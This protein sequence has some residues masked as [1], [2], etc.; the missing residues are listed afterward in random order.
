MTAV[1]EPLYGA[2]AAEIGAQLRATTLDVERL[3]VEAGAIVLND[4]T[5]PRHAPA[6]VAQLDGRLLIVFAEEVSPAE[7]A[8]FIRRA[9]YPS[10]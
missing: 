3:A 1:D 5:L 6:R 7:R 10:D 4:R 9:L 8:A 2:A